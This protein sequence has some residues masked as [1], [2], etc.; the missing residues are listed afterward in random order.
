MN[1]PELYKRTV[2]ILFDAYFNDTLKHGDCTACAVGNIIAANMGY[3][4]ERQ[5]YGNRGDGSWYFPVTQ[6][7]STMSERIKREINSTGYT[8]SELSQIEKAFENAGW[9][10]NEEEEMFNGLVAVLD[11]LEEIHGVEP[12]TATQSKERFATHYATLQS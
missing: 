6:G 12:S 11:V 8:I 2:D 5:F 3:K 10:P 9:S 4:N 1:N 7:F